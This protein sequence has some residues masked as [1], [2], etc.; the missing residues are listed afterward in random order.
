MKPQM[1]TGARWKYESA[2]IGK[3][4]AEGL[5]ITSPWADVARCLARTV[6][7]TFCIE[8]AKRLRDAR[9]NVVGDR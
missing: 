4:S 7:P 8:I 2:V 1:T 9:V 6:S 5:T 3:L